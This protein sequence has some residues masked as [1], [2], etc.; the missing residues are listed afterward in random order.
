MMSV[1]DFLVELG[2][3][4]LLLKVFNSFGEVF[5]SGIEKGFKVVGLSY[6]VVC[7]YVVLCCFVVLVE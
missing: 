6:V 7:F 4:E 2:I 1:K 5:F 3:E